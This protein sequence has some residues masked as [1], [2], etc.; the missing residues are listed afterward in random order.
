MDYCLLARAC[1]LYRVGGARSKRE[2]C[3]MLCLN[4]STNEICRVTVA[5][6]RGHCDCQQGCA[7]GLPS[8]FARQHEQ[9]PA[10]S[11]LLGC[12]QVLGVTT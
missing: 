3:D 9:L 1:T 12:Q 6:S 2:N 11:L 10:L 4:C 7:S 8:R 5:V